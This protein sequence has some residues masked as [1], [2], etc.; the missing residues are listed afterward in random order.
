MSV[1][2]KS[3][4]ALS[5]LTRQWTLEDE[6]EQERERRQ[7]HRNL[8]FAMDDEDPP[9]AERL[10]S[11][12][13]AEGPRPR[14]PDSRD[15]E[16]VW[17]VLR[18]R[19][20]RR[21]RRREAPV[22]EP[23]EARQPPPEPE[24]Q[25]QSPSCR[26]LRPERGSA[27]EGGLA[28]RAPA[29][30]EKPP[31]AGKT[32][33]PEVSLDPES[34]SPSP[35]K[36]SLSQ[37]IA[38]LEERDIAAKRAVPGK[39]SVSEK[40]LVSEKATVFQKTPAPETQPAPG[41]ATAPTWPQARKH[42][43]SAE[44][45][46]SPRGQRGAG[47]EKEPESSA[48]PLPR[49]G[50]LPPVTLQVRT[51]GTEAEVKGL[52]LTRASP[53]FSSAPH[54]SSP[55]TISFPMSPRR[56]SS[57]VALTHSASVRLL[58]SSAKTAPKLEQYHLAIQRSE[59]IKCANLF[60]TEFPVAPVD[61]TSIRH[62]FENEVVGQSREGPASSHKENLQLSGVV[63]SRL[64]LWIS[65][66]QESAQ[67]GQQNQE[68][69]R[70][71]AAGRRPQWRK[72][73]EPLLGAEVSRGPGAGA[74]VPG[75]GLGKKGVPAPPHPPCPGNPLV[76]TALGP[77]GVR[78]QCQAGSRAG[79]LSCLLS[80]LDLGPH[81]GPGPEG[82]S[83]P[84]SRGQGRK[85]LGAPPVSPDW[86]ASSR[87]S[88]MAGPVPA[89]SW[90]RQE[91]EALA[92]HPHPPPHMQARSSRMEPGGWIWVPPERQA[93]L[94]AAPPG[95]RS[96]RD[97]EVLSASMLHSQKSQ[98]VALPSIAEPSLQH[99]GLRGVRGVLAH[100]ALGSGCLALLPLGE[101]SVP[102]GA[103]FSGTGPPAPDLLRV[104]RAA[105]T[106]SAFSS[107]L[108]CK[109]AETR[110]AGGS[111]AT[112]CPLVPAAG[113]WLLL[114]RKGPL[115][116]EEATQ[117]TG[118]RGPQGL[119]KESLIWDRARLIAEQRRVCITHRQPLAGPGLRAQEE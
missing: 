13:E 33:E 39:A 79:P 87:R 1:S 83:H 32:L 49:A 82:G 47:P 89:R 52:S 111:L 55:R 93:P 118:L 15:E 20:E 41:R 36:W 24:V 86:P 96:A 104:L 25:V 17:A 4:A 28:G 53:T 12:E 21:Q 5:S 7:Q 98:Q 54:R 69:Q 77:A 119:W 103:A 62:L 92:S 114:V 108:C 38:V 57:E 106:V 90:G 75:G 76:L 102:I 58:A 26:R 105:G 73:P 65:R 74:A 42:Q 71:L 18:M 16:D 14:A 72:K 48:G 50:R 99:G 30:S 68:T 80:T 3:W 29:G 101:P 88:C 40:R 60:H 46:S 56:D 44:R 85:G 27:E 34:P 113:S 91:P 95:T 61:V 112:Y 116:L 2:R 117:A 64:N 70:E 109:L 51:P 37:K 19:Q 94:C 59:S 67:Q 63:R 97:R 35:S 9:A 22:L 78:S 31:A 66:T 8:S 115:S 107:L 110:R 10:L 6:E 11:M 84:A 81:C 43:A 100:L 23:P 45:P